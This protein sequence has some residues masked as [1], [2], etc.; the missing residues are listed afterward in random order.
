MGNRFS[1][2]FRRYIKDLDTEA[3]RFLENY[4]CADAAEVPQAIPRYDCQ[5]NEPEVIEDE[6]LSSDGS[7][8]GAIAF[9]EG[10]IEVFDWMTNGMVGYPI[11]APTIFI[12]AGTMNLGRRNNTLAHECYH[13]FAHRQYFIYRMFHNAGAEFAFRCD[14]KVRETKSDDP[15][16]K[17]IANMEWQA[18]HM[19]PK[20]LMP[21]I[22][23]LK[24]AKSI[25][26]YNA[27]TPSATL[28]ISVIP[29]L[30]HFLS[31]ASVVIRLK[32]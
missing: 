13:W 1:N 8:D 25:N 5:K 22:A 27:R 19:A 3:T 11:G 10:T 20:I 9:S 17:D 31:S 12:D 14:S 21:K 26:R 18:K 24:K 6:Y 16:L 15:F 2:P 23:F 4:G 7:V 32:N 29:E 30:A 28:R